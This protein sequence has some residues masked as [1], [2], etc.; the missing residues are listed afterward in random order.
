MWKTVNFTLLIL[1]IIMYGVLAI[2][3]HKV[4][5][6]EPLTWIVLVFIRDICDHME[7][8]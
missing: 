6:W 2:V 7:G 4:N 1:C 3:G 5:A 8:K